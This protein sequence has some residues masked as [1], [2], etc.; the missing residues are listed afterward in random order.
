MLSSEVWRCVAI[1][2]INVSE[3]YIASI[4]KVE[5]ITELGTLLAVTSN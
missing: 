3:E 4:I 2:R 1:V 5:R